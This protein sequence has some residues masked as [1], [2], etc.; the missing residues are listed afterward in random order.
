MIKSDLVDEDIITIFSFFHMIVSNFAL[1]L[2]YEI[3]I[4]SIQNL[5]LI[6]GT[7]IFLQ[8]TDDKNCNISFLF[9]WIDLTFL[10]E[11]DSLCN[12]KLTQ[13]VYL[14]E[15]LQDVLTAFV[16]S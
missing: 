1:Q 9:L 10:Q 11:Y 16:L 4:S 13:V 15:C 7:Y 3:Y 6:R 5:S 14:E 2:H 12:S 8:L